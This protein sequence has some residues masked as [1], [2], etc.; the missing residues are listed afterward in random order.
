MYRAHPR[1]RGENC[2]CGGVHRVSSGSSPLTRGKRGRRSRRRQI[3]GLIPAHA[4]KTRVGGLI[5]R[6]TRAHP[7]SRGENYSKIDATWG[8]MGSSPLTRGKRG[9]LRRGDNSSGLI[10][11]HA[12]KTKISCSITW[13]RRAHPRSR[14]ENNGQPGQ[15]IVLRGSSPLTRGKPKTATFPPSVSWLIPAHAGK[16]MRPAATRLTPRAHPRSRGENPLVET[17]Q[18]CESGSSPLTRGKRDGG[19]AGG[20]GLGLI[21]A[22]AG[23]TGP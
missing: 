16:T 11:A 2:P 9:T 21:P 22:H 13:T 18:S 20:R 14:G 5:T 19:P 1:S 6:R 17:I 10:P 23:K 12:G 8:A 7:R 15:K 3:H 4:G